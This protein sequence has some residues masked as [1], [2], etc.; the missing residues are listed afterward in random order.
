MLGEREAKTRGETWQMCCYENLSK[1]G[2]WTLLLTVGWGDKRNFLL[3]E[4]KILGEKDAFLQDKAFLDEMINTNNF[5]VYNT[6][7]KAGACWW[8]VHQAAAACGPGRAEVKTTVS[9]VTKTYPLVL[10]N[11]GLWFGATPMTVPYNLVFAT[12]HHIF[13][14]KSCSVL[15]GSMEKHLLGQALVCL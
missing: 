12:V 6:R 11:A 10:A 1:Q 7:V 13:V 9:W 8:K 15:T 2:N 4:G 5:L 3:Y 14:L